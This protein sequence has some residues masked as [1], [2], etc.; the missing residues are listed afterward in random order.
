MHTYFGAS[1]GIALFQGAALSSSRLR[2]SG[3]YVK[4]DIR[5]VA[6]AMLKGKNQLYYT[7]KHAN[8]THNPVSTFSRDWG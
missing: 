7:P 1:D 8:R 5:T 2:R 4:N 6:K 3:K